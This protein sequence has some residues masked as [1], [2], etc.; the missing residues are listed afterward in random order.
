M[1]AQEIFD[2]VRDHLLKQNAKAQNPA[3]LGGQCRYRGPD[4]LQC[5]V[6]CLIT[7]EE[8]NPEM[9]GI[10]VNLL[11]LEFFGLEHLRPH[12]AVLNDLQDCHDNYE[13]EFWA[14]RLKEIAHKHGL[15]SP[16]MTTQEPQE[17]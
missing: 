1:I 10:D 2:I 3:S 16:E 8:Y 6:G 9:E 14:K 5:A 15:K 13:P 4:G 7:D 11:D 12:L 17:P